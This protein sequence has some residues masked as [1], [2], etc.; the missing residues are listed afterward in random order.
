MTD[1]DIERWQIRVTGV[2][3]GVGFRQFAR[4]LAAAAGLTGYVGNDPGGVFIEAQGDPQDLSKFVTDLHIRAPRMAVVDAVTPL[5][6]PVVAAEISFTIAP[7]RLVVDD[8]V[9]LLPPDTAMCGDCRSELFD[10]RDRRSAY[11]FIACTHCGPRFTIA[12][13]VPYDRPNTTMDAFPLCERCQAEYDD[14]LNRRYRAQPT[15]CPHCGPHLEYADFETNVGGDSG[16]LAVAAAA[17]A[18]GRIVAVKGIG[19]YHLACDANDPDAVTRL[20]QRKGRDSKPFAVMVSGLAAARKYVEVDPVAENLLLSTAAPIVV[21]PSR[22]GAR[23]LQETVAPGSDVIGV[24][25]AYSPLHTLLMEHLPVELD[26]LVMTSGNVA[27]EPICIDENESEQRLAGLADAWL[28]HDRPIHAPCDDSVMRPGVGPLRR[29]RGYVPLPIALPFDAP[30]LLAVGGELQAAGG[31]SRGRHA[32]LTQHV[33]DMGSIQTAAALDRAL[34]VVAALARVRPEAVVADLHPGYLSQRWA[35]EQ[36]AELDVPLHLVQHDH[37]HLASLLAEHAVPPGDPVLGFT[38]DA[39]SFGLD[40]GSWGGELLLGS[41]DAVERVGHLRPV[42]LPGGKAATTRPSRLAM[43]HLAAAGLPLDTAA[44]EPDERRIVEQMLHTGTECV[45]TTSIGC[46]FD[47]VSSLLGVCQ[48]V[49]YEGQAATE[50][51][52]LARR[53]SSDVPKFEFVLESTPVGIVLDPSQLIAALVS[54]VADGLPAATAAM[55]FHRALVNVMVAAAREVRSRTGVATVGLT[56]GVFGNEVLV[57][58]ASVALTDAGFDVL[59]HRRVPAN[60]GGLALGQLAV[61]ACHG[62]VSSSTGAEGK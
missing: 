37:A 11:P 48:D 57:R 45:P 49:T 54:H 25:I 42:Q 39:T 14:P 47:A 31:V 53:G 10:A 33:G 29:S 18:A 16:A 27:D 51:E 6:V 13:G 32:W 59:T 56:G 24:M 9:A 12:S 40:A 23:V 36:A 62:Y 34:A 38:F 20:R 61:A 41:Y 21:L 15:A 50:L 19:G 26:V 30:Q 60:D 2:V 22:P 58:G 3:Q 44:T 46:L 1:T 52:A 5:Q 4:T 35:R 8:A 17:L 28:H 7:S 55:G 43:A